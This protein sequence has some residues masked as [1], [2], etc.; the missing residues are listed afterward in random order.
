MG[1]RVKDAGESEGR[2][3]MVQI[4]IQDLSHLKRADF[5]QVSQHEKAWQTVPGGKA[6]GGN[7]ID[8]GCIVSWCAHPRLR[9]G[10]RLHVC[11][12]KYG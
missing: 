8:R 4:G 2:I 11:I 6:D 1:V 3:V 7:G 12:V 5:Q 10:R 9:N